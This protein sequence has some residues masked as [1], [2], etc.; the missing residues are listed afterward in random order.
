MGHA[1]KQYREDKAARER[2]IF[3]RLSALI[4]LF[5]VAA[6]S[7]DDS[8]W[9]GGLQMTV[10]SEHYDDPSVICH[11]LQAETERQDPSSFA[12]EK[13][14]GCHKVKGR[15]CYVYTGDRTYYK[16]FG[17]LVDCNG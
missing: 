12:V 8:G 11:K 10:H 1:A 9:K 15:D 2:C 6:C 7:G 5:S 3:L 14:D 4:A 17:E 16:R 13:V